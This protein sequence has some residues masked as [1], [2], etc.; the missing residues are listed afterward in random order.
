MRSDSHTPAGRRSLSKGRMEA[1]S[2][3]VFAIAITLLVL[4]LTVS[5]GGSPLDQ[6]LREWPSYVAYLVSF[7]TVGAAWLGHVALTDRLKRVDSIFLRLNLLLLMVVTLLPFPTR[8]VGDALRDTD[9]ERVFVTIYGLTLLTIRLLVFALDAY[10]SRERLY[11]GE[12]DEQDEEEL[13]RDRRKL[14]PVLIGYPIA[15]VIGLVVPVAAV[16]LY[17]ALGVYLVVPFREVRHL[18]FRRS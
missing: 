17:M 11:S 7:L 2:D 3:G 18:L 14:L 8:L 10:A 16:C 1:F 12:G 5:K 4:D 15:I 9:A 13:H 6:V